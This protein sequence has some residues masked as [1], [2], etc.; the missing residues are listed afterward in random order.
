LRRNGFPG[1]SKVTH[2]PSIFDEKVRT[3]IN[4]KVSGD[5]DGTPT[6]GLGEVISRFFD[7]ASLMSRPVPQFSGPSH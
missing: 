5:S 1:A 7:A 4:I 6:E 2:N 3:N